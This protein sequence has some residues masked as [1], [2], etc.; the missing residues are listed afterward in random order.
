MRHDFGEGFSKKSKR[1]QFHYFRIAR[2]SAYEV[3]SALDVADCFGVI[4]KDHLL[5]GK[6]QCDHL[7][8]MITR[9]MVSLGDRL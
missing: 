2:G 7:A 1:E 6:D 4:S 8:A 9:F 3:S 5:T